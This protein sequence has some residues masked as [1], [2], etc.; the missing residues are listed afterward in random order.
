LPGTCQ[1]RHRLQSPHTA[2]CRASLPY[3]LAEQCRESMRRAPQHDQVQQIS[4]PEHG[5]ERGEERASLPTDRCYMNLTEEGELIDSPASQEMGEFGLHE[6]H[7]TTTQTQRRVEMGIA[8]K[9]GEALDAPG[10]RRDGLYS[11]PLVDFRV[12]RVVEPC[13]HPRHTEDLAGQ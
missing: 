5:A 7:L 2:P 11:K 1:P 10:E 12:P 9:F 6:V 4:L 8:E 3:R 13:Y